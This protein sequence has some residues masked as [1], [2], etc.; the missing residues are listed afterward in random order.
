MER[1]NRSLLT[2]LRTYVDREGDWETHLQLLLF[3]YRTTKHAT[4]GL[5]LY[6]VLFGYTPSPLQIP[7]LPGSVIPDPAEYSAA[8]RRKLY[9]LRELVAANTVHSAGCRQ[10]SYGSSC[11]RPQLKPNQQVLLSNPTRGKLGPRWTEPWTVLRMKNSTTVQLRMG[12]ANRTVHIN[13][14]R[15]LL[16]EEDAEHLVSPNWTPPL[17]TY[18]EIPLQPDQQC[19]SDETPAESSVPQLPGGPLYITRSGRTV[20]PVD[21]YGISS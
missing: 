15:P 17:F 7:S 10:S 21:R 3:I 9:D 6:E 20:K 16:L 5:S 19:A 13:R 14:V 18:E 1:M 2:L 11:A 12:A 8:L 4:T